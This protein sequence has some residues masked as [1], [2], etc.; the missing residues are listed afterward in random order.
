MIQQKDNKHIAADHADHNVD[1]EMSENLN[2]LL[3][4]EPQHTITVQ[5][6]QTTADPADQHVE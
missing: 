3:I 5:H 2:I 6:N 4:M 1:K